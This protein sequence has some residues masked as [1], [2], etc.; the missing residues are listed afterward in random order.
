MISGEDVCCSVVFVTLVLVVECAFTSPVMTECCLF[1]LCCAVC[2]VVC[3]CQLFCSV[4][5]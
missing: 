2:S 3:Q 5:M 4:W 1:V